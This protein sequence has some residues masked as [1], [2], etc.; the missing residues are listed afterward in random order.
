MQISDVMSTNPIAFKDSSSIREA[1]RCMRDND[2][3]ILPV[4]RDDKLLG[5]V[6]DRDLTV[7]ALAEGKSGDE[8]LSSI[9][10]DEV[11][12]C[13]AEDDIFQVLKNMNENQI[14]RLV[15][16]DNPSDKNLVGLVSLSDIADHCEDEESIRAVAECCRHYH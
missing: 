16:L 9:I 12:Y 4:Y 15:V 2:H 14:Q 11:L 1:A 3:G 8:P 5:M 10:T 13:F 6:T 7:R